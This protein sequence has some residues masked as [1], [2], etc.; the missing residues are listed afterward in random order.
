MVFEE[1]SRLQK[2]EARAFAGTQIEAFHCPAGVEEIGELAFCGCEQL[3]EVELS[4][5]IK[6]L[7]AACFL[8]TGV[9]ALNILDKANADMKTL[10]IGYDEGRY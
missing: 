7:G 6:V 8:G 5:N 1:G 2:I 3:K 10:G 9:K 4:Y